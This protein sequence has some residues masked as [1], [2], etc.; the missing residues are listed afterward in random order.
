MHNDPFKPTIA[1]TLKNARS[2]ALGKRVLSHLWNTPASWPTAGKSM[3]FCCEAIDRVGELRYGSKWT[4]NEFKT[5]W[6]IRPFPDFA[7]ILHALRDDIAKYDDRQ[8]NVPTPFKKQSIENTQ[9][10]P[11]QNISHSEKVAEIRFASEKYYNDLMEWGEQYRPQYETARA[12]FTRLC[13]K[14]AARLE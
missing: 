2:N 4:G 12:S 11:L 10:S 7:E 6:K 14:N 8:S 3:I 13:S 9:S 1:S 5:Y